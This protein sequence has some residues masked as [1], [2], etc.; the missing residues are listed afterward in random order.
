LSE[1]PGCRWTGVPADTTTNGPVREVWIDG[2]PFAVLGV[3]NTDGD[4]ATMFI[5]STRIT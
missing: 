1:V 5:D 4:A 2:Y 3:T